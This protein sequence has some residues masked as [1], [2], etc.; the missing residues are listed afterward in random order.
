M[1]RENV[2][3][4]DIIVVAE[5]TQI[6][7]YIGLFRVKIFKTAQPYSGFRCPACENGLVR[8]L[9]GVSNRLLQR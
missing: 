8:R 3:K 7:T 6:V 5:L 4:R 2:A 9:R 1:E